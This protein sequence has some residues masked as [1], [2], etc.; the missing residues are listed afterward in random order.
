MFGNRSVSV[1]IAVTDLERRSKF[2]GYLVITHVLFNLGLTNYIISLA[3][4]HFSYSLV[5]WSNKFGKVTHGSAT[6]TSQEDGV[7]GPKI[8]GILPMPIQCDI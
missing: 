6:S 7:P 5:M 4:Q 1:P 3:A 8:F 2:S